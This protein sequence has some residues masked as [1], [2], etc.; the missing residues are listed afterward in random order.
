M[1]KWDT[2]RGEEI[3][4]EV[5]THNILTSEREREREK[6]DGTPT[7]LVAGLLY[8]TGKCSLDTALAPLFLPCYHWCTYV[9][10]GAWRG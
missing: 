10:V 3:E 6:S 7:H 5:R 4:T 8:I 1:G 2:T 9:D